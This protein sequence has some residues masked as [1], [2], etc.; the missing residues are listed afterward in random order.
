MFT[1]F[2]KEYYLAS[3]YSA[4]DAIANEE[5]NELFLLYDPVH[6]LKSIRNNWCTEKTQRPKYAGPNTGNTAIAA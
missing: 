4:Q 3:I 2:H 1:M 6:L 5:Y